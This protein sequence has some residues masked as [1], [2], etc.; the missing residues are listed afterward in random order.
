MDED[1]VL[2]TIVGG[3]LTG[4]PD[5]VKMESNAPYTV[6]FGNPDADPL[7]L[8]SDRWTGA[9]SHTDLKHIADDFYELVRSFAD[10]F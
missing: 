3:V 5:D 8:W 2:S 4:S 6:A 9:V 1:A 10:D 7:R